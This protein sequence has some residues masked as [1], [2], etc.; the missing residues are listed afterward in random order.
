[1]VSAVEPIQIS[2]VGYPAQVG[3]FVS[4]GMIMTNNRQIL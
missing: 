1:M 4:N 3:A 2:P